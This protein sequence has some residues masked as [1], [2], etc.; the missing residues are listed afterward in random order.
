M[1]TTGMCGLGLLCLAVLAEGADGQTTSSPAP[2]SRPETQQRMEDMRA[3]YRELSLT[4]GAGGMDV[5]TQAEVATYLDFL[6]RIQLEKAQREYELTPEQTEVV[7]RRIAQIRVE[8]AEY[9]REHLAEYQQLRAAMRQAG[10][11][12]R[13][14]PQA[15]AAARARFLPVSRLRMGEPLQHMRVR[16]EIEK[17]LPPAQIEAYQKRLREDRAA[18]TRAA[19]GPLFDPSRQARS[20]PGTQ[21]LARFAPNAAFG[22]WEQYVRL[23]IRV[24][25]LEETQQATAMSILRELESCRDR[26]LEERAEALDALRDIEDRQE[27]TRRFAELSAPVQTLFDQL[28]NRLNEIPTT[29]QREV[30]AQRDAQQQAASQPAMTNS[31][32]APK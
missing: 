23:F 5:W 13:N 27:R 30:V 22:A 8:S 20:E 10:P 29:A 9:W 3:W 1:K 25:D 16:P 21:A 4:G 6:A 32:P 14:D 18:M 26:Y 17:L 24:Y 12:P 11:P 7:R 2:R 28:K 15:Q 19:E 31:R